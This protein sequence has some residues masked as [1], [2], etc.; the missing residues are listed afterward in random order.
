MLLVLLVAVVAG[1]LSDTAHGTATLRGGAASIA[2]TVAVTLVGIFVVGF[3]L[4]VLYGLATSPRGSSEREG[5][6]RR[7]F[8]RSI[9]VALILPVIAAII[10]LL[11]RNRVPH[12][13]S[14]IT[15][16]S[17]RPAPAGPHHLSVHFVPAASLST[18]AIV[19]ALGLGLALA[20]WL[21][22]RRLGK[23]WSLGDILHHR[24]EAAPASGAVLA[25][26]L[27]AVRVPDPDEEAD[28]RRAVVAA[29]VAMTTAA[30]TAGAA[31]RYDE[32]PSEFLER[33]LASLGA[34]RQAAQRLT[35][36]FETARYSTRPFEE[37]LR[38]HAID[39]LHQVQA[40]LAAPDD[41]APAGVAGAGS[42][43]VGAS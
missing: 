34:S 39:A 43:Y 30:A 9:A 23:H 16:S 2:P 35:Y 27:A 37:T 10:L 40:E 5:P 24:D 41:G 31:R 28:P 33:L 3:G 29:Y 4:L 36:L 17:S 21:G 11:H 26:S 22:A 42:S 13:I 12:A 8:W 15:T 38:A 32:T 18:V 19:L 14:R 20:A 7:P 1:S 6:V 25:E